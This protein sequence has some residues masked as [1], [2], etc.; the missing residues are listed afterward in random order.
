MKYRAGAYSRFTY[1]AGVYNRTRDLWKF[2][3]RRSESDFNTCLLWNYLI[4]SRE[5]KQIVQTD[6]PI[7]DT[8][9]LSHGEINFFLDSYE[10]EFVFVQWWL[11]HHIPCLYASNFLVCSVL[12][13][14]SSFFCEIILSS[15]FLYL[16]FSFLLTHSLG[17]I[18]VFPLPFHSSFF[19]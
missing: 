16:S 3:T 17:L 9:S 10:L 6:H 19:S 18:H 5:M 1:H 11:Y 14:S 15:N 7:L 13:M 2:F 12:M 4:N 8:L